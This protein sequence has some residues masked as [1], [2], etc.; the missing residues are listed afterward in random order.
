MRMKSLLIVDDQTGIRLLLD[1]IFRTE[2]HLTTLVA[3]G[4]KAIQEIE[5]KI[6]DCVLLDMNMPGL[7]GLEVL[8]RIK[9]GWPEIPV[10]MMTAYTNSDLQAEIIESGATTFFE[11]PF[12][13]SEMVEVVNK[14][15]R[16]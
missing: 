7:D 13:I 15:L 14:I 5:H 10:I 6:P 12:N 16:S 1:E 9:K 8:R 2:G 3:N 11:K 4:L